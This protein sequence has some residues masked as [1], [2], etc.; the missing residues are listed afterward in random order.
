MN[1]LMLV[2]FSMLA[3][4]VAASSDAASLSLTKSCTNGSYQIYLNGESTMFDS[5]SFR[6]NAT[7]GDFTSLDAGFNGFFPRGLGE[8]FTYINRYLASHPVQGGMGLTIVGEQSTAKTLAFDAT[9]IGGKIDTSGQAGGRLFLANV[10]L[11]EPGAWSG[12]VRLLAGGQI[13]QTLSPVIPLTGVPCLPEPTSAYLAAAG[14]VIAGS[15]T[16]NSRRQRRLR[17]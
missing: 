13:I 10:M 5:F 6:L 7:S 11:S 1:K 15:R 4:A 9:R 16:I 17:S 3:G 2:I 14:L 12:E 8:P